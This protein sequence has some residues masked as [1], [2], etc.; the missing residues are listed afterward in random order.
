MARQL[1]AAETR[2]ATLSGFFPSFL[3]FWERRGAGRL[4]ISAFGSDAVAFSPDGSLVAA[5]SADKTVKLW[6]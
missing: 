3:G 2:S 4:L 6:E 5:A 1:F